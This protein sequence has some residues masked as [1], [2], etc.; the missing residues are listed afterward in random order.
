MFEKSTDGAWPHE[1]TKP[2]APFHFYFYWEGEKNDEKWI[3]Q[4]K[5]ALESVRKEAIRLQCADPNAPVYLNT[6]LAEDDHA[7][8]ENIYRGNLGKLSGLRKKY[9][10]SGVMD[11]TG[12]FRVPLPTTVCSSIIAIFS[13]S[14][15]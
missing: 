1:P 10:P 2:N 7:T 12:G 15:T 5:K 9:D 14:L 6:A 11:K 13:S 3:A 8:V 4:L